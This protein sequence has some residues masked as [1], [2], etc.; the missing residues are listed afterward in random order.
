MIYKEGRPV[1]PWPRGT[2]DSSFFTPHDEQPGAKYIIPDNLAW[3][4]WELAALLQNESV[5]KMIRIDRPLN[6]LPDHSGS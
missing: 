2:W 1:K 3:L 4:E 6:P 5:D